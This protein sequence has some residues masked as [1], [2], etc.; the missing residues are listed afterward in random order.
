MGGGTFFLEDWVLASGN[1]GVEAP[2]EVG[3]AK[4]VGRSLGLMKSPRER[5]VSDGVSS[6]KSRRTLL[7]LGPKT[8]FAS[9]FLER[10]EVLKALGGTEYHLVHE[11]VDK[12]DTDGDGKI[13]FKEFENMMLQADEM[14][15][16]EFK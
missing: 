1:S 6:D 14:D 10:E 15:G 2:E 8:V 16:F 3:E 4:I 9:G 12:F 7:L 5:P 11:I 13:S